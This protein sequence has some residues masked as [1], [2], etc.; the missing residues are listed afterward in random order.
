MKII[1]FYEFRVWAETGDMD[2]Y[3]L[4]YMDEVNGVLDPCLVEALWEIMP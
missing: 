2:W 4:D 3:L 1:S